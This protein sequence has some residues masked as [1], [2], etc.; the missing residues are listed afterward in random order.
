MCLE[1]FLLYS[2]DYVDSRVLSRSCKTNKD[3]KRQGGVWISRRPLLTGC[4]WVSE[5]EM[6]NSTY[7][8]MAQHRNIKKLLGDT[9]YIGMKRRRHRDILSIEETEVFF[10]WQLRAVLRSIF[11]NSA[12]S[13][14][15]I[16]S[17]SPLP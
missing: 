17:M 3:I 2:R 11:F 6:P 12:T 15:L 10:N 5:R 8:N 4:L 7:I 1:M 9:I 13:L 16:F 14:R